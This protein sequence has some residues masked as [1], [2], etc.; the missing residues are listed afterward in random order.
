MSYRKFLNR[1]FR[2]GNP[3]AGT[4]AG[5]ALRPPR[6]FIRSKPVFNRPPAFSLYHHLLNGGV[7]FITLDEFTKAPTC[8]PYCA[9]S[10]LSIELE[11]DPLALLFSCA[12][13][14]EQI[15]KVTSFRLPPLPAAAR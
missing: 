13:C 5:A 12:E 10:R 7:E 3:L 1:V 11:L 6:R 14:G 2:Q 4:V 9:R 15:V 8:C